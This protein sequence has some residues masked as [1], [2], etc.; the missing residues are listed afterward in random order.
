MSLYRL[1]YKLWPFV[2]PYRWLVA[3]TLALTLVGSTIAQV[4]AIVLDRTVDAINELVMSGGLSWRRASGILLVITIVLLGKEL[5]A[6]IISYA[7]NFFGEKIRTFVS[8]D[9]AQRAV[10]FLLT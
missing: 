10:D 9:L 1:F 5:L 6:V 3:C 8:R 4:N 2:K 7:Q